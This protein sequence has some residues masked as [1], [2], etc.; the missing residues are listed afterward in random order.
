[1]GGNLPGMV[2]LMKNRKVPLCENA[3]LHEDFS[4]SGKKLIPMVFCHGGM[5]PADEHVANPM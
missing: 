4:S 2:A 3:P 1:M 5:A